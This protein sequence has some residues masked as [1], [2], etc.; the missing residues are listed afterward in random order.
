MLKFLIIIQ[1]YI[2]KIIDLG[3]KIICSSIFHI[4]IEY[5]YAGGNMPTFSIE[6]PYNENNVF[7]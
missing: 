7:S 6:C 3:N 5:H 1:I 4:T 2:S